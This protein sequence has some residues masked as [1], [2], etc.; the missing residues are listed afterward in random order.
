MNLVNMQIMFSVD[1]FRIYSLI[2]YETIYLCE[3]VKVVFHD[4]WSLRPG[5][6]VNLFFVDQ[7]LQKT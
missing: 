3:A 5:N 7:S 6:H 4:G 1:V 2:H